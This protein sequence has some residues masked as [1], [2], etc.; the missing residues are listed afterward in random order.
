[1]GFGI[2][3][4]I[5]FWLMTLCDV[6]LAQGEDI[7][8]DLLRRVSMGKLRTYQ[9]FDQIKART[10]LIKL[11]NEHLRKAAPRLWERLKSQDDELANDLAQA[12]LVA[13]LDM[14]VA[15]L[16]LLGI[17]HQDGFFS[18]DSDVTGYLNEGWQTRV[19]E[20]LKDKYP[21][22][23]VTFYINHLGA[24]T[25]VITEVFAPAAA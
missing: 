11:N 3:L 10:H 4:V 5:G 25:K 22:S 14:I 15:A 20:A 7:F 1:M 6:F 12:I 13:H 23:V 21:P 8:G 18:K 2:A 19:F 9:L 17:P 24:E 16:D